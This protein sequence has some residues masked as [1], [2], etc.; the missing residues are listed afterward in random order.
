[1]AQRIFRLIR[2]WG[3]LVLLTGTGGCIMY[4]TRDRGVRAP[5]GIGLF[6]DIK[7]V[8]KDK[9]SNRRTVQRRLGFL[10]TGLSSPRLFWGRWERRSDLNAIFGGPQLGGGEVVLSSHPVVENLIVEFDDAGHILQWK[11]VD[12]GDLLQW[13]APVVK[14]ARDVNVPPAPIPA[15]CTFFEW[16]QLAWLRVIPADKWVRQLDRRDVR[17]QDPGNVRLLFYLPDNETL[18]CF[19][20]SSPRTALSIIVY[21]ISIGEEAALR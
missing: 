14:R 8:V 2:L 10:D 12:D 17:G 21:M 19:V 7:D 11:I 5:N 3:L 1:M 13:L 18:G 4:K 15:D 16:N 9:R 20:D 6:P